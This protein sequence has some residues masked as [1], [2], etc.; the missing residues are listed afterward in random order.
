M[1]RSRLLVAALAVGAGLGMLGPAGAATAQP[2]MV[3][4]GCAVT[5]ATL[6]W[7]FK[8]SFRAYIDGDIAN[9]EW[10]TAGGATYE[11]PEF[12]WS[13][14]TGHFDPETG[15]GYVQFTGSV[16]FTGHEGL[17]DTTIADPALSITPDGG[18]LILDVS[19]PSM[20]GEQI[21]AQDVSFVELTGPD[22]SADGARATVESDTV[23]TAEGE[24]AFPDY[25]AGT[26]FDPI[27]VDL[28]LD[29][30]SPAGGYS[31]GDDISPSPLPL[32]V[33]AGAIAGP[34]LVVA[35]IIAVVVVAARRRRARA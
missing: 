21:D 23:L 6:S 31:G 10:T 22:V 33:V 20:E 29:K 32:W 17:L 14:G 26:A 18:A 4:P 12:S 11:T 30:C 24:A 9:G 7:G 5:D 1:T 15:V 8:E 16:R 35:A 28:K 25:Q 2:R 3:E 34:L 27:A 19:G 13:D